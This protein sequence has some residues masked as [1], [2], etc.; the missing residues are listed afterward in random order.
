[1][2]RTTIFRLQKIFEVTVLLQG[3]WFD[4]WLQQST[5][6]HEQN[7]ESQNFSQCTS[8]MCEWV[9]CDEQ[10]APCDVVTVASTSM[11]M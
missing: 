4:P 6:V 7:T 5:C 2:Q 11:N 10:M 1:M 8:L 9:S 3:Q